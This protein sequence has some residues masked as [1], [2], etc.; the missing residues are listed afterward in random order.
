MTQSSPRRL[1]RSHDRVLGGVA[2]GLA[3]Y[4]DTDPTLVRVIWVLAVVFGL[5]L[6]ILGY[7]IL[8][9]VMPAPERMG[10]SGEL[11]QPRARR[12][13]RGGNGAL[14]LGLVLIVVG[15][16]FL[17]PDRHFLPW[18]GWGL[19]RIGWP[20]LLILAGLLVLMRSRG[21]TAG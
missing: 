21:N 7:F 10:A 5:P 3:D 17:L 19:L 6:A 11:A 18:F 14:I 20:L 9:L 4:L 2:G 13:E 15:A 12:G 8:W 1:T 16:L